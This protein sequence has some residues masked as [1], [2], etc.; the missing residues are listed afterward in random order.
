[1]S[2]RKQVLCLS[3]V[4][5]CGK[6]TRRQMIMSRMRDVQIVYVNPPAG[7]KTAFSSKPE[8]FGPYAHI[9]VYQPTGIPKAESGLLLNGL[10]SRRA[11]L[12]AFIE[13]VT[14]KEELADPL[15]WLYS[16]LDVDL[17]GMIPHEG[18]VYDCAEN[19]LQLPTARKPGLLYQKERLLCQKA[20]VVFAA[21]MSLYDR[22]EEF[23]KKTYLIPSGIDYRPKASL[24]GEAID[25]IARLEELPK[26]IYGYAGAL[27]RNV[28]FHMLNRI[29]D[30]GKGLLVV[31]QTG[32]DE[33]AVTEE[34][35]SLTKRG[36]VLLIRCSAQTNIL[37]YVSRFDVCVNPI[38]ASGSGDELN[39][40][41]FFEYLDSG[42]P[43]VTSPYPAIVRNYGDVA[44][45]VEVGD[46]FL[47]MVLTA[48][49]RYDLTRRE[50]QLGYAK[51][52]NWDARVSEMRRLLAREGYLVD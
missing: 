18:V 40:R 8:P 2:N 24:S 52:C 38:T 21:Q 49:E 5:W 15:L 43:I 20:D 12:A 3:N 10:F 9:R 45:I 35:E 33:S 7:M 13:S 34:V 44:D 47:Q 39:T 46:T 37:D 1:M 14:Q 19:H 28:D 22:I 16:P 48:E 41:V 11:A 25:T 6:T 30:T 42:K 23:N 32:A 17:I 26:P 50:R 4:P 51:A 29:A 31:T 27:R 36:N